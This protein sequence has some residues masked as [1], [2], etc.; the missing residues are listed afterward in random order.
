MIAY[1]VFDTSS[2]R[3]VSTGAASTLDGALLQGRREP[4]IDVLLDAPPGVVG[5]THYVRDNEIVPRPL[6]PGFDK[7]RIT[8][9]GIDS[10]RLDLGRPFVS[11]IDGTPHEVAD[12]VLEITSP[13]PATYTVQV[14]AFPYQDYQTEI[15]ACV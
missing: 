1:I 15:V 10:A 9:D 7:T 11:V 13:M 8:A 3:I 6:N 14:N 5:E 12:G 4:G 2:G